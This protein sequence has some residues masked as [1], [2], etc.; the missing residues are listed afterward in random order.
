MPRRTNN[1]VIAIR[2]RNPCCGVATVAG[3]ASATN[4]QGLSSIYHQGMAPNTVGNG[5]PEYGN[6]KV[7]GNQVGHS[8]N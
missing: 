4:N 6:R 5:L 3:P 1:L 8:R 2:G 7:G